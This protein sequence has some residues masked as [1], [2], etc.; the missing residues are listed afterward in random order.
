MRWLAIAAVVTG[1][2]GCGPAPIPVSST[3]TEALSDA[4]YGKIV[5][6]LAALNQQAEN[7]LRSG[8]R[9]AAGDVVTKGQ[10]LADRLMAVSRPTLAAT[11][12]ASDHDQLYG[13]ML[14]ENGNYGWA[15]LVFQK[16]RVRW[17]VWQPQTP[18]TQRRFKLAESS[19]AECDRHIE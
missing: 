1:L 8:K 13:R 9:D 5:E 4:E 10:A 18:D 7:L 12:A 11:E 19:I 6:Q 15:R 2:T 17:K 14:L 3:K 16:N